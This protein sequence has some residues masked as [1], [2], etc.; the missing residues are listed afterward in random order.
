LNLGK[1]PTGWVQRGTRGNP[2]RESG[3]D[4]IENMR[5]RENLRS[6][7]GHC[8]NHIGLEDRELSD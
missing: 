8:K 7:R 3:E 6:L 1:R 2:E 4:G 5:Q